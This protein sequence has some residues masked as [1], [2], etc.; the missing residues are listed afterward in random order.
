VTGLQKH[1]V[2]GDGSGRE[3]NP[4]RDMSSVNLGI[5]GDGQPAKIEFRHHDG[6][7]DC[8]RIKWWVLFCGRMLSFAR[9][10][11]QAGQSWANDDNTPEDFSFVEAIREQHLLEILDFPIQGKKFFWEQR[12]IHRNETH[13]KKRAIERLV[14][15]EREVRRALPKSQ[16]LKKLSR[17]R[18]TM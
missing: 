1:G 12:R 4:Y 18:V 16:G 3:R 7:L 2:W 8:E 5:P 6:T 9:L 14:I 11:S 17:I 15:R 13:E 10:I